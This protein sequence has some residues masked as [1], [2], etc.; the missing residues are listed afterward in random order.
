[1][2]TL[3]VLSSGSISKS[4]YEYKWTHLILL[5]GIHDTTGLYV[6]LPRDTLYT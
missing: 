4:D 1:M 6:A 5:E 2:L 3:H